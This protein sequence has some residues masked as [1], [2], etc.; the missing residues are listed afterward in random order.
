MGEEG[1]SSDSS[2][3]YHRGRAVGDRR[4][5]GVGHRRPDPD[6]EPP[7]QAAAPQAAHAVP[8][9]HDRRRRHRSA[10]D[11]RQQ[12]RTDRVRR[13]RHRRRSPYYRNAIGDECV[14]VESGQRHRRDGLRAGDLP[15]R[16]LRD[17]ARARPRTAGCRSE[18]SRLYP[19]EANS[20][21]HPPK[22]YLSRFGQLLEHAPYCE[23]DLHPPDAPFLVEG[24][25]VEVLVKHRTSAGIVGTRMTY[26]THPFDVVGLGRLPLPVHVQRR[27]LRADHRARAPAAAGAPGLRGLEL[28]GLQ[29]LPAQGRLPPAGDPGAVLPLERRQ[30]R[31]HVLRRRRLRGAQGLRHQ[32][33]L[34]LAAPGRLRARPAAVGDRGVAGR[35]VLRGAGG[36]GRHVRAA[37]PGRGRPGGRGPGVRLDLGRPRSPDSG[38]DGDGGPA[39]FSNS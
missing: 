8:R 15:D 1:F 27:G 4:Q 14:Y 29:L 3:L 2:L 37:R 16:R 17:R 26:A 19:I 39:V 18:P 33:R 12:R 34:D 38:G 23:R 10:A 7:A 36:H 30:R 13:H 5:P 20:H 35:G 21:I 11:P 31:G 24:E 6:P 25:D 28:R 32:H 9:G 22:R